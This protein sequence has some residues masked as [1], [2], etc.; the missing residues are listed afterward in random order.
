MIVLEEPAAN[1]ASATVSLRISPSGGAETGRLG[2]S[3][4]PHFVGRFRV[5]GEIGRGG[6]GV[7][8]RAYDPELDRELAVKLLAPDIAPDSEAGRRFAQEA[9]V[10][11]RLDH[12]DI[13]PVYEAGSLAD[14]RS[15]FAMPLVEGRTLAAA[16]GDRQDPRPDL[17]RWLAVF[18]RVCLA[19]GYAH[20]Q[21]VVH[22]DL[23]PANVMLGRAGQVMV[24]D[25]GV[26]AFRGSGSWRGE[27]AGG[28]VLGT[29]AYMAPEQARGLC[30]GDPRG[31]VFGLGAILCEILTG[32]PPYLGADSAMVTRQAAAGDL[33]EAYTRLTESGAAPELIDLASECLSVDLVDRPTDAAEVADRLADH[34]RP[35][36]RIVECSRRRAG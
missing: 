11:G 34:L 15:F 28:W 16:L 21:G 10:A 31:D 24:M 27:P 25:W 5:L 23:K 22:R 13:L 29:P 14:G 4:I 32:R 9:R 3:T 30:P 12:P 8:L 26:A 19:V 17:D 35:G 18:G 6:M 33:D 1:S 20:R 2:L 36:T 7:V